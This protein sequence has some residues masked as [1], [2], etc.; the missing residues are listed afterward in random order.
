VFAV[1]KARK[2]WCQKYL[3]QLLATIYTYINYHP[4]HCVFAA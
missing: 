1:R 2:D 4:T 3:V